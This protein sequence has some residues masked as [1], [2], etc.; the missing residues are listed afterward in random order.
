MIKIPALDKQAHFWAG[1]AISS[2]AF[3]GSGSLILAIFVAL[4]AAAAKEI[5]RAH[6]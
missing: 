2:L 4:F 3:I 5:G 6:V 1:C